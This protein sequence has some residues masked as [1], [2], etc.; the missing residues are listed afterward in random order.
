MSYSLTGDQI[1]RTKG[2]TATAFPSTRRGQRTRDALIRAARPVFE[3]DGFL[4][5]RIADITNEAGVAHGTFY[6][7]FDSKEAVFQEVVNS[8]VG[9][10]FAATQVRGAVGE[11]PVESIRTANRL[12]LEAY[13]RNAR[14][15][16]VLEEVSTFNPF[17][18]SMWRDIRRVFVERAARGIRRLQDG[19]LADS[20]LDPLTAA[21][22]L[23]GMVEHFAHV[24]LGLGEQFDK[25]AAVETLTRLWAQA[26]GLRLTDDSR[27]DGDGDRS[28]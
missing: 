14:M 4:N 16:K 25:Q 22:A 6:T 27:W 24:W 9:D 5:A 10:M 15:M 12:Y 3:N 28:H 20:N 26:I 19:G 21:S 1:P 17:F 11:N 18:R 23:G 8:L 2:A 13:E 7:Y